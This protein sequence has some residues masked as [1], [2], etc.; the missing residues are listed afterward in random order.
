MSSHIQHHLYRPVS[1]SSEITHSAVPAVRSHIL[2]FLQWAPSFI[3]SFYW[4]DYALICSHIVSLSIPLS[5]PAVSSH[6][7][8][9]RQW[10]HTFSCFRQGCW[11]SYL[12]MIFAFFSSQLQ[13]RLAALA[14]TLVFPEPDRPL[15]TK[16]LSLALF[17]Y[18][19]TACGK[20]QPKS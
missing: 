3:H 10:A 12:R 6:I 14:I 1:S 16:G 17:R 18:S 19:S 5:I 11:E 8:L 20:D 2:L 15:M 13:E 9:L 4:D 7:Q